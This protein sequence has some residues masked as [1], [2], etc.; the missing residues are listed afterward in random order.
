M[1]GR[2]FGSSE[3]AYVHIN[4]VDPAMVRASHAAMNSWYPDACTMRNSAKSLEAAAKGLGNAVL[5]ASAHTAFI[6]CDNIQF[7]LEAILKTY[8]KDVKR[9]DQLKPAK[10]LT[11]PDQELGTFENH[12]RHSEVAI[13]SVLSAAEVPSCQYNPVFPLGSI[14]VADAIGQLTPAERASS[15]GRAALQSAQNLQTA[16]RSLLGKIRQPEVASRVGP[17]SQNRNFYVERYR[18]EQS[19]AYRPVEH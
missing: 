2:L 12:V 6:Q 8:A 16:A 11:S 3:P 9:L 19:S 15:H 13:A 10:E 18:I 7:C 4:P 5:K 1:F 17:I 14:P